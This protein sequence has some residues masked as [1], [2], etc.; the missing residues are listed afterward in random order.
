MSEEKKFVVPAHSR[1]QE[2]AD[3]LKRIEKSHECPFCEKNLQKEH[4]LPFLKNGRHWILTLNQWPYD[5]SEHH[6]LLISKKHVQQIGDLDA[7]A[8]NE[9]IELVS[10]LE[11]SFSLKSGGLAI[12]FGD[13]HLNGGTVH[14]LHAHVIFPYHP[15][16][17][18]FKELRFRISAKNNPR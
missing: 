8:G 9:L 17:P 6:F 1:T 18:K 2:Q 12:R 11:D 16:N 3:V 7:G 4:K 10:S 5:G 14:H 13:P 15:D